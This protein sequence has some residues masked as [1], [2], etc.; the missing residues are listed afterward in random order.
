MSQSPGAGVLQHGVGDG[1]NRGRLRRGGTDDG[2]ESECGENGK[3][4]HL[5]G[6]PGSERKRKHG[7]RG[8]HGHELRAV[9]LV[10]Q[11]TRLDRA[12]GRMFEQLFTGRCVKGVE[13]AVVG[14]LEQ[15]VAG[16]DEVATG[17][18]RRQSR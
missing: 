6:P 3:T 11:G 16:G 7:I 9:H 15:H 8:D 13:P 18:D 14:A 4:H 2:D 5:L 10:G 12:P 1:R 17:G